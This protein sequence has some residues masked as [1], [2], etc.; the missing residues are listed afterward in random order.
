[1]PSLL[2]S[3]TAIRVADDNADCEPPGLL[4]R[5]ELPVLVNVDVLPI[6]E[7][8]VVSAKVTVPA[9]GRLPKP[10]TVP[11]KV[12]GEVLGLAERVGTGG[13]KSVLGAVPVMVVPV[14]LAPEP[15]Q[16]AAVLPPELQLIKFVALGI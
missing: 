12:V 16:T 13:V 3:A 4:T 11:L 14:F 15:K 10:V 9:K 1:M 5:N 8:L 2:K 7:L 6:V